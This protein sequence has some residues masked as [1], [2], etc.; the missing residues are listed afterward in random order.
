MKIIEDIKLDFKDVLFRPKRST[1]SSRS[2][3]IVEREIKF[4][5]SNQTWKGVPIIASNMDTIGTFEMYNELSKQKIITCFHK[6]YDVDDY[7][8]NL[9]KDFYMI[10][11]GITEK[12][13]AKLQKLIEKLDP[14]FV[15]IDVANGYMNCLIEFV[16][17]VRNAYPDLVIVCG[18]VVTREIVEDLILNGVDIVKVGI[19]SGCFAAYTKVLMS[20]GIYKDISKIEEG[21]EVINKDGKP[22]KVLK[23]INQ[24]IKNVAKLRTNNW[25]DDTFVTLNHN[26]WIGDL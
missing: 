5:H 12:D 24:G 14:K 2:E 22:V 11:T 20:N 23:K 1:L 6:H 10:S 4:K 3:V 21:E 17:R 19:G 18:N 16:K 8:D 15:C 13:W 25:H 26:Y 7:P 9:D